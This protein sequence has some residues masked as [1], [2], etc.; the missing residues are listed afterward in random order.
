MWFSIEEYEERVSRCQK[1]LVERGFDYV[2]LFEP[3]AITYFTGFFTEGYATSFQFAILPADA[4]PISVVRVEEK[5][6]FDDSPWPARVIWWADGESAEDV[7]TRALLEAEVGGSVAFEGGSW[8]SPFSV[9][10]DMIDRN[11]QLKFTDVGRELASLRF[12][13]SRAEIELIRT[14]GAIV[15]QMCAAAADRAKAGRSERELAA[16]MSTTAILAGSDWAFPGPIS[17][18]EAAKHIHAGYSDRVLGADDQVFI[19][20]T[21]HVKHHHARCMR[22][23]KIGRPTPAMLS[24]YQRLVDV[25]DEALATVR[26]GTH[27]Q[28]PDQ[29]Y[30]S[31]ILATE[32]V[33]S[34]PNKTFYGMGFMLDPNS[35][36][37]LEVTPSSNFTFEAGMIFHTYMTVAGLNLSNTILVT[38]EGFERMTNYSRDLIVR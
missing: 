7:V 10:Q 30:R 24:D 15:D 32:L 8:R 6:W 11:P 12:V 5:F 26:A 13:K 17:S 9:I 25:Q 4:P 36:E 35:Y 2:L 20:A 29:I 38:E 21:A 3:E 22:T 34:Y 16:S 14:A 28:V 27:S 23:I 37:P 31:G 19:E 18:G 1:L 33:K